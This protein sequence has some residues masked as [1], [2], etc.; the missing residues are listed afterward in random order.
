MVGVV[1]E[2]IEPERI[3]FKN[4]W[5]QNVLLGLAI[6]LLSVVVMTL[7]TEVSA[8]V[9]IDARSI[10]LFSVGL[11]FG[12][13]PALFAV[14]TCI[15]IRVLD[16][17]A[18]MLLGII[19][20]TVSA[21]IGLAFR[22][23]YRDSLSSIPFARLLAGSAIVHLSM[24]LLM[25]IAMQNSGADVIRIAASTLYTIPI[26]LLATALYCLFFSRRIAGRERRQ[27]LVESEA[28]A[29]LLSSAVEQ[30]PA[31]V[32]ITS[33]EGTIE[34]VNAKFT[35]LTGYTRE[36]ALGKNPSILNSGELPDSVY[37][38]MWETLCAGKPWRG[39]FHNKRKDGSLFWEIAL[40]AP[41]LG[42]DGMIEKFVALKEDITRQKQ[43][44]ADLRKA[45]ERAE[46]A[47]KAKSD[48]LSILSHELMTPLNSIVGPS[49]FLLESA[50]E[51][52]RGMLLAI[53][54]AGCRLERIF[55]DLLTV[56]KGGMAVDTKEAPKLV[57][58]AEFTEK[59]KAGHQDKLAAK[60][61]TLIVE[62]DESL[63]GECFFWEG[64]V[65]R[66]INL[67]LENATK[68]ANPGKVWL[69]LKPS[70]DGI[71]FHLADEGPGLPEAVKTAFHQTF[72]QGDMSSTRSVDGLGLGLAVCHTLA[73]T[74]GGHITINDSP[75]K[76]TEFIFF[77]P[78]IDPEAKIRAA[79]FTELTP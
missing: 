28:E 66:I 46:A 76:G 12:F 69:R 13:V 18:G 36:E 51:G 15:L 4:R 58:L 22:R 65:K 23:E 41:I 45:T 19:H 35:R 49:E 75:D 10:L 79:A 77:C 20:I 63:P 60:G 74:T 39:E 7:K 56:A 6:V 42:P 37:R 40:I 57:S 78:F 59:A 44:E 3:R 43:L 30:S 17:G 34:Y 55:S 72:V 61:K 8:G 1:L 26:Y 47:S 38:E 53:Q 27:R 11:Y 25:V 5:L 2:L 33:K 24:A 54:E 48:F 62:I 31:S 9:H 32:V 70:E 67:M 16:G 64:P 68:H 29:R 71:A 50:R 52:D 73:V 21:G 14:L